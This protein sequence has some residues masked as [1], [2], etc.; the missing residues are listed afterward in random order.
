[1][2]RQNSAFYARAREKSLF[3]LGALR[4]PEPRNLPHE[5][6]P[7]T[8]IGPSG[9]DGRAAETLEEEAPSLQKVCLTSLVL[10]DRLH[11]GN[12]WAP[13]LLLLQLALE[14]PLTLEQRTIGRRQMGPKDALIEA[15]EFFGQFEMRELCRFDAEP[16]LDDGSNFFGAELS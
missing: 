14:L 3:S 8:Y 9:L 4:R 16:V 13:G 11:D 15:R 2:R 1:M 5:P 12:P 6:Q 7:P 10:G